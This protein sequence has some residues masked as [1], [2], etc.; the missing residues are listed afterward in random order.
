M[1]GGERKVVVA[2]AM[3]NE[4][5]MEE[6][7]LRTRMRRR[8]KRSRWEI[9]LDILSG[10]EGAGKMKKTQ[11]MYNAR[12]DWRNFQR[13]FHSLVERGYIKE[14]ENPEGEFEITE[15]GRELLRKLKELRRELSLEC[16]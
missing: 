16:E 2:L 10:I 13:Y 12:L 6:L 1:E 14:V 3:Q 15:R 11:I 7:I 4:G 8:R 9:I 5:E